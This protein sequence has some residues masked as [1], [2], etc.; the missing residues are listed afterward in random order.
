MA[1]L[2]FALPL[3]LVWDAP[4]TSA[5][6]EHAVTTTIEIEAPPESVW[7]NVVGFSELPSPKAWLLNTG[8]AIPIRARIEG[9]GVGAVRYCEF[10]TGPFIEPITVW[11]YPQRL[12]FDVIDQPPSM[13]EWS[14]Y[15]VVHAPHLV[16]GLVSKR[17]QFK[18][19]RLPSGRTRLEGTTWYTI[20]MAPQWYWSGWSD[21]LIHAIH[22]R[23]LQ[24]VKSLSEVRQLGKNTT[25]MFKRPN[26]TST[27]SI[28]AGIGDVK[29]TPNLAGLPS[30]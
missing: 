26:R 13:E 6:R 15:Q 9:S 18:L 5:L 17:G 29:L 1:A 4:N 25:D 7:P 20:A 10:T 28:A 23:V 2:T 27:A 19:V 30:H 11:D 22:R 8:I 3:I 14:P 16:G 12:A 21:V 24:H